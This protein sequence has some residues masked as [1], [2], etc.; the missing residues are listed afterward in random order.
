MEFGIIKFLLNTNTLYGFRLC[1]EMHTPFQTWKSFDSL[2]NCLSFYLKWC[3][4]FQIE[5]QNCGKVMFGI[6]SSSCPIYFFYAV[7]ISANVGNAYVVILWLSR[8]C[9]MALAQWGGALS[10]V[11]N[12]QEMSPMVQHSRILDWCSYLHRAYRWFSQEVFCRLWSFHRK[13]WLFHIPYWLLTVWTLSFWYVS[14]TI[15]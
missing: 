4:S 6:P 3:S 10:C 11:N 13:T 7:H 2:H 12:V 1:C 9:L 5:H 14:C 15:L 8:N